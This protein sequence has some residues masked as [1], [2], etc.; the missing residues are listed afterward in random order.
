MTGYRDA[1]HPANHQL[2]LPDGR[3]MDV[4]LGGD[5]AGPP[6]VMHHGTPYDSTGFTDWHQ[7]CMERG[8]RLVS[9]S[10]PGYAT[11]T[12]LPGRDV[13]NAARDTAAILDLLGAETFMTAGWSGGGPHALACAALLPDRCLGVATLAGAGRYGAPDLDFLDGMGPE[14]V[15]EFGA[16]LAGEPA[17]RAW[18]AQE[19]EGYRHITA[20]QL[21]EALGGLVPQV[22]RDA[23][24]DG[25]AELMAHTFRRCLER[26][27]D[28]WVDDDLAFVR[29]WGFDLAEV[30]APV[31]VWQGDLD[32]MVPFAHGRWLVDHLP[33]ASARTAPGHG[34]ISLIAQ[35]REEILQGLMESSGVHG[36]GGQ[37]S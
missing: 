16:A 7:S 24:H 9:A 32:L 6:L 33:T 18:M 20:E 19:G 25:H 30:R 1:V 5:P 2:T 3:Q 28:G 35:F 10:R 15:V 14:N 29:D 36:E 37:R 4:L 26:G 27:F 22:D 13:A 17:L 11:S 8:V 23:L 31:T 12:R 21:A 34:H